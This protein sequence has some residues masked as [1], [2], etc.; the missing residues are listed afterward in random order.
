[1]SAGD[2]K[3][4]YSSKILWLLAIVPCLRFDGTGDLSDGKL[5]PATPSHRATWRDLN[6]EISAPDLDG[7]CGSRPDVFGLAQ[8]CAATRRGRPARP[9]G[10]RRLS[11]SLR[12]VEADGGGTL[13]RSAGS[14]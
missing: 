1:M 6:D 12:T 5:Q 10:R 9:A 13:H 7:D 14:D 2:E 11:A 8:L 3:R 4:K